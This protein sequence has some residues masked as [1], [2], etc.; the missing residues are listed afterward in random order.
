MVAAPRW[1]VDALPQNGARVAGHGKRRPE[2]LDALAPDFADHKDA[3]LDEAARAASAA[4]IVTRT[5]KDFGRATVPV[6]TPPELLAA[7]IASSGAQRL[8]S[9]AR[10]QPQ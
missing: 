2:L 1:W 10:D 4:A 9:M 7:V 5:S 8:E 3:V 6:F